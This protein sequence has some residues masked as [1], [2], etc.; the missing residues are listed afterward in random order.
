MNSDITVEK[1]D[2]AWIRIISEDYGIL[3]ELNEHFSFFCPGY[4]W[5]PKFKQGIWDGKIKIFE[6][7]TRRLPYG[8]ID[9]LYKFARSRSYSINFDSE[10][11]TSC[12]GSEDHKKYIDSLTITDSKGSEISPRDYQKTGVLNA[13]SNK[14]TILQSPTASGKSL[15]IYFLARYYMDHGNESKKILIIVPTTSLVSQMEGDFI[16]YSSKDNEFSETDIHTI[17]SGRDKNTTKNVVISTWQSIYKQPKQWFEQFGM[18]VGDEAHGYKAQSLSRI[19][20]SLSHADYR[21]GTTGTIPDDAPVNK[22]VLIGHF[23]PIF[24]VTTTKKLMDA[25]TIAS[26]KIQNLIL[27]YS[28][29]EKRIFKNIPYKSEIDY[30]VG[31]EKR[32]RF[33]RNL[34]LNVKGNTLVLFQYVGKHGKPLHA[35]IL[36]H[37]D[38]KRKIFYVSGEVETQA[39]ED[40]RRIVESEEN[41][42]VVASSQCFSTGINIRNLHNI[43]FAAPTK[44]QIRVLQSI[45]RGLR[46]SDN[47]KDTTLYDIVDDLSWRKRKNYALKHGIE[48]SKI[49]L[50]E[51]FRV[52]TKIIDI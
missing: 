4:K 51:G 22:L 26:L 3:Q 8:L 21:I 47:G 31:H 52:D 50:K 32:N 40:I 14:R 46:K 12:G 1:V 44:S 30:L 35:D 34:A 33:I 41:A 11:K 16:D 2:E 43:I 25:G 49:Y 28:D 7:K 42:I 39:R 15:M 20:T 45:G 19:M 10:L 18:V 17:M 48:R 9:H 13:L 24:Q 23:G 37:A 36:K 6:L 27:N 38:E 29:D 5:M